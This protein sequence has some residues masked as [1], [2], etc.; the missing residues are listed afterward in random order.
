MYIINITRAIKKMSVKEIRDF[1]FENY[2][3]RMGFFYRKQLLFN[4]ML[5]KK[6]FVVAVLHRFVIPAAICNPFSP[7]CNL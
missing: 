4:E 2:C 1:I 3:K 6:R 7:F 5:G